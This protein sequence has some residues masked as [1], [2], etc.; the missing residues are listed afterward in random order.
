MLTN[1][2]NLKKE[3]GKFVVKHRCSV[4]SYQCNILH[5]RYEEVVSELVYVYDLLYI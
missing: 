1:V 3:E 2:E 5:F 4:M